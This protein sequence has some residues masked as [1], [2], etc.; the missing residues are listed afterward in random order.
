[1][2]IY[3]LFYTVLL[4]GILFFKRLLFNQLIDKGYTKEQAK[5]LVWK[6][7]FRF[8]L[9]L[10]LMSLLAWSFHK[11]WLDITYT[12]ILFFGIVF[13]YVMTVRKMNQL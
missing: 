1:M 10:S 7:A 3:I 4:L 13:L 5:R 8:I 6:I 11:Q 9:I 2:L 12:V